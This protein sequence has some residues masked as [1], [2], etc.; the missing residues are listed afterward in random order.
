MS[1]GE[2]KTPREL[3]PDCRAANPSGAIGGGEGPATCLRIILSPK[4]QVV[5]VADQ[6][7]A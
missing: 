6:S 4:G 7:G 1:A 2:G 3:G 5:I